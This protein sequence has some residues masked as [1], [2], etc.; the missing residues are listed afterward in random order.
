[1][2]LFF[3]YTKLIQNCLLEE[4]EGDDGAVSWEQ[5]NQIGV[6]GRRS[7]NHITL[8][9]YYYTV[10]RTV[11][12]QVLQLR[13]FIKCWPVFKILSQ[14]TQRHDTFAKKQTKSKK[15]NNKRPCFKCVATLFRKYSCSQKLILGL[16]FDKAMLRHGW[17][18]IINLLQ[19]CRKVHQWENFDKTP[20][21]H[22][23]TCRAMLQ[24]FWCDCVS[25]RRTLFF[26]HIQ[27]YCLIYA[28]FVSWRLEFHATRRASYASRRCDHARCPLD[29]KIFVSPTD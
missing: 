19:M 2:L 23:K 13:K 12:R 5:T 18:G 17:A 15:S 10:H 25:M 21:H 28:Q 14:S 1:M 4:L 3:H 29:P 22:K 26:I 27:F 24:P 6:S 20:W 7:T 16:L 11:N 9:R 8:I